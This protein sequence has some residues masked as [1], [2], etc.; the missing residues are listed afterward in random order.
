MRERRIAGGGSHLDRRDAI[1]MLQRA[2]PVDRLAERVDHA[3]F[4]ARQRRKP[5]RLDPVGGGADPERHACAEGLYGDGVGIDADDLA[6]DARAR[7][8]GT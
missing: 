5:D 4:P 1:A 8:S 2:K 7:H 3:A 6:D